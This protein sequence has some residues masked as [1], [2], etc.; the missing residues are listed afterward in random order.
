MLQGFRAR[1]SGA[2]ERAP[3]AETKLRPGRDVLGAERDGLIVLLDLRREVYLG[4]DEVGS[5]I[6]R[7]IEAGSR[8]DEVK[9]RVA[10]EF[11]APADLIE[12]DTARFIADLAQRRLIQ[13]S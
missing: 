7:A 12:R 6:W 3:G 4:L 9:Q 2:R 11:D 10:T 8:L 5:A 13:L 1:F